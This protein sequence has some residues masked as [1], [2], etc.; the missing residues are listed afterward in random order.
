MDNGFALFDNM[1][2][3]IKQPCDLV[4]IIWSAVPLAPI[5][6]ISLFFILPTNRA[7][8][9]KAMHGKELVF[10][11]MKPPPPEPENNRKIHFLSLGLFKTFSDI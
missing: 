5:I 11:D 4:C 6:F 8:L 3:I 10:S 1:Q 7:K 2:L 9:Y